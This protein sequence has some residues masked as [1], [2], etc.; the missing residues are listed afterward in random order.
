MRYRY[1]DTNIGNKK[2]ERLKK[3]NEALESRVAILESENN[4][5]KTECENLYKSF[6]KIGQLEAYYSAEISK[7]QEIRKCYQKEAKNIVAL[8][9]DYMKAMEKYLKSLQ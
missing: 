6:D 2:N 7:V 8:K 1:R 3:E 5:L 4:R 9:N